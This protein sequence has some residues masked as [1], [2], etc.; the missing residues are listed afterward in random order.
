MVASNPGLGTSGCLSHSMDLWTGPSLPV[1]GSFGHE[2]PGDM[3]AVQSIPPRDEVD[4]S[5]VSRVKQSGRHRRSSQHVIVR[6]VSQ[7]D[8]TCVKVGPGCPS[9]NQCVSCDSGY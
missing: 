8:V 4:M 9:G 7:P 3:S 2:C 6:S 5:N 1:K